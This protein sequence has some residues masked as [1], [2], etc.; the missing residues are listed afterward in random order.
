MRWPAVVASIVFA[1]LL[2]LVGRDFWYPDEPDMA[3][4]V[5]QM[6]ARRDWLQL[7]LYD[8]P[9]DDYPPLYFWIAS[10]FASVL[11]FS[12]LAL[13]L[14]TTLACA[15][16]LTATGAW[17]RMRFGD[18][19]ALWIVVVLGSLY[20]VFSQAINM[21][22]DML[23]AASI[24]T[25]IFAFDAS[26][27]TLRWRP[28]MGL[29]A[30]AALAM[31]SA[32][33][34]KGPLGIA[35]PCAVLGLSA[36]LA[37][38]MRRVGV[39]FAVALIAGL[40][41]LTWAAAFARN[42]GA[43]SVVYFLTKQNVDRFLGGRSH[44]HPF[45]YYALNIWID[46]LPW[47]LLLVPALAHAWREARAGHAGL[48]LALIWFAFGFLFFSAAASKRNVYFLPIAPALAILLGSYVAKLV[49]EPAAI[50]KLARRLLASTAVLIGVVGALVLAATYWL[51][52]SFGARA[53]I[54]GV[55]TLTGLG[56]LGLGCLLLANVRRRREARALALLPIGV[57]GTYVLV[58]GV[59]LATLDDPLS[60]KAD[61]TWLRE[62]ADRTAD[63]VGYFDAKVLGLP[64]E[65]SALAFYGRFRMQPLKDSAQVREFMAA[66]SDA[67]IV[68]QPKHLDALE[69]RSGAKLS[70]ERELIIGS[71]RFLAVSTAWP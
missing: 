65:S 6:L 62:R 61:A 69:Q 7:W 30:L 35:L 25:C 48:R 44:E 3:E 58:F 1:Q 42:S 4:I 31:S 45:Y 38:D 15:V 16:L 23:L 52:D 20:L 56:V 39:L 5:R 34:I 60:A 2:C 22:L 71:D 57:I 70:V 13:R 37:R 51:V 19:A 17:T 43:E 54:L 67:I 66:N 27:S 21:H 59:L 12:E 46:F 47:S 63:A 14:P 10:A 9:F 11:G 36:L 33:L 55:T 53:D 24:A 41:F 28:R 26:S 18:R 8:K 32:V 68:V 50:D 49:G 29:W 40:V 64:K